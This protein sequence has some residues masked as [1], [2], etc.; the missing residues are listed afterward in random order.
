MLEI[1]QPGWV[2]YEI[3][4]SDID[5]SLL[6]KSP[7][8]FKWISFFSDDLQCE[9]TTK[10]PNPHIPLLRGKVI[11]VFQPFIEGNGL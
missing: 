3:Y 8:E 7:I 10:F 5:E 6:F 11:W 1:V 9:I 4:H 2:Y